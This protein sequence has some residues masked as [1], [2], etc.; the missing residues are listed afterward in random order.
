MLRP[1]DCFIQIGRQMMN[2]IVADPRPRSRHHEKTLVLVESIHQLLHRG[3][4]FH[5]HHAFKEGVR[6]GAEMASYVEARG[7]FYV[8]RASDDECDRRERQQTSPPPGPLPPGY[9]PSFGV[10]YS[11]SLSIGA[12]AVLPKNFRT[13]K[14][15]C[16]ARAVKIDVDYTI[17]PFKRTPSTKFDRKSWK[18]GRFPNNCC[19]FVHLVHILGFTVRVEGFGVRGFG[20]RDFGGSL[21]YTRV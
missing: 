12:G 13:S 5:L 15:N 6:C 18:F 14:L 4:P 20:V 11:G 1:E 10:P 16:S 2:V 19:N 8:N 17:R 7:W 3:P 9:G 21:D